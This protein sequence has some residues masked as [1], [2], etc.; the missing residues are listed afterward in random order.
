MAAGGEPLYWLRASPCSD[1]MQIRRSAGKSL[2]LSAEVHSCGGAGRETY[3][4]S[5]E[6][7]RP[8]RSV[9][10]RRGSLNQDEIRCKVKTHPVYFL[11][12]RFLPLLMPNVSRRF[13]SA[14][15]S[16]KELSRLFEIHHQS[17][18]DSSDKRNTPVL[19][20][21]GHLLW[22]PSCCGL[23]RTRAE[24]LRVRTGHSAAQLGHSFRT[25]NKK[26]AEVTSH[27]QINRKASVC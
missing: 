2:T 7:A 17:Q 25:D 12:P 24:I 8:G 22:T 1:E 26:W 3:L 9:V 27:R 13:I 5:G 6:R 19:T 10:I 16:Q 11:S 14:A 15:R 20:R 4:G 21:V 23:L 18:S